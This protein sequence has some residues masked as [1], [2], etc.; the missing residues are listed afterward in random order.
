[1][2]ARIAVV[3]GIGWA[4]QKRVFGVLCLLLISSNCGWS[5]LYAPSP[6][7]CLAKRLQF[8]FQLQDTLFLRFYNMWHSMQCILYGTNPCNRVQDSRVQRVAHWEHRAP[9]FQALPGCSWV[10]LKAVTGISCILSGVRTVS[11]S[12]EFLDLGVSDKK[13]A[14]WQGVFCEGS[15]N[16]SFPLVWNNLN[17]VYIF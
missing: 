11:I 14:S 16:V 15:G 3:M 10:K 2:P 8:C 9:D 5:E 12:L 6:D 7:F 1:M 4:G 17:S 13:E